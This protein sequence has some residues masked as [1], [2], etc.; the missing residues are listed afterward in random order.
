MNNLKDRFLNVF[1][2]W[3][4]IGGVIVLVSGMLYV[5]VRQNYRAG[6]DDPQVQIAEDLANGLI[7]G[8][9]LN[10]FTQQ[11]DIDKSLV[12]Y[13]IIFDDKGEPVNS[14]GL[15]DGK[16]PKPPFGVLEYALKNGENRISWEIKPGVRS[17][18]VVRP[19]KND[20]GSGFILVG[21]NM[22]E[23]ENRIAKLGEIICIGLIVSM[24]VS[25]GLDFVGDAWRRRSMTPPQV[26]QDYEDDLK[27]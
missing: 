21:R 17:A 10:Q 9:S 13:I 26:G 24:I 5:A 22:R 20:S 19:Y 12:N 23:V 8:R 3:L 7:A 11:T 16:V 14:S 18:I 2:H 25:F 4:P 6:L 27:G 1:F 15:L